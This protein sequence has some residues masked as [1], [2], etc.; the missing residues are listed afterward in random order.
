MYF[1]Q[2]V[3][4]VSL[5]M[6]ALQTDY[7]ASGIA[8]NVYQ[9]LDTQP[10]LLLE[11]LLLMVLY[12]LLEIVPSNEEVCSFSIVHCKGYKIIFQFISFYQEM[13]QGSIALVPHDLIWLFL[14]CRGKQASGSRCWLGF[15]CCLQVA[16]GLTNFPCT[17]ISFWG[18]CQE[19]YFPSLQIS[20]QKKV[21][22]CSM[23]Y[24]QRRFFW[25]M[26]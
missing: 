17:W 16:P 23:P 18:D 21:H 26:V 20:S 25:F 13:V 24:F 19:M 3:G 9:L 8:S 14:D 6:L 15:L 5:W 11:K 22:C 2:W 10:S 12:K 7:N 4:M 1:W